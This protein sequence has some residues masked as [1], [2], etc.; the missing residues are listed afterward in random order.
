MKVLLTGAFGNIGS[1]TLEA[2]LEKGHEVTAFDLKS[3]ANLKLARKFTGRADVFWGDVRD[4]GDLTRAVQEQQVVIHLAYVIPRLSMTGVN[5]EDRPDWAREI[6][7][8]GTRRLIQAMLAQSEPPRLIFGSSLHVFGQTQDQNPPRRASDPVQPVE[9]YA[10]HKVESEKAVR[11]SRLVWSIYR[12]AAALPIRLIMDPGMFEVPLENRIEYVHPRDVAQAF[13][14]GLENDD[15]WGKTLLI[16][17]GPACQYTYR[18]MMQQVLAAS[19]LGDFP[20]AAFTN[21]PYSTDWLD[22]GE[23]QRLLRFQ[24]RSLSDYRQELRRQ[25]GWKRPLVL[26]LRPLLRAWLLK[27]SSYYREFKGWAKEGRPSGSKLLVEKA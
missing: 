25:L 23:S 14:N 27:K 4:R 6:N 20:E 18:E 13:A 11:T 8:G 26:L 19:G 15:I 3:K 2:L 7:V 10:H 21:V 5:S 16:G 24:Q 12:L 9:H 22:T 1:N 17:G